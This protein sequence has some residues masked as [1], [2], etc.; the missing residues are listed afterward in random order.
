[1]HANVLEKIRPIQSLIFGFRNICDAYANNAIDDND[2]KA[3]EDYS[4]LSGQSSLG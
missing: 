1:M 4:T 2:S 3:A